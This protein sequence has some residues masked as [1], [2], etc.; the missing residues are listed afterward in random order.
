VWRWD[1][2]GRPTTE[3]A[4]EKLGIAP[5]TP[6]IGIFGAAFVAAALS[7]FDQPARSSSI[8]RL[9]P[10]ERFPAAVALSHLTFNAAAVVGP[11]VGG[12]LWR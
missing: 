7:A 8:P 12:L 3:L 6:L 1:R 11:A 9:V 4:K 10:P 2:Q 5:E